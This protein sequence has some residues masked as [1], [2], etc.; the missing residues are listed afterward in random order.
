MFLPDIDQVRGARV[1]LGRLVHGLK[2]PLG[3]G[4][5]GQ[6][7]VALLSELVDGSRRL[8][9]K[10][11]IAGQAPRV[12]HAL[13]GHDA[14]QDGY[15]RVVDVG[16]ADHRRDHGGGVRLGA[17]AGAAEGLVFPAEFLQAGRLVAKDLHH[18]L[19]AH[20]LLNVAVQ[21]TQA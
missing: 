16:N 18:L 13:E 15:H 11:Q 6:Q 4:K 19:S 21:V 17:G 14:A 20:H 5:G 3:A 12:C 10:D 7:E 9:D 8:A 1:L 2:D